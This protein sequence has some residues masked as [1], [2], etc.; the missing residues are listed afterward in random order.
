MPKIYGYTEILGDILV[1]GSFS[2]IGSASTINTTNLVVSDTIISLGHSQSG[3]PILDEG[4]MFGRGTGLTQAFIW[5]ESDDTFA[6]VSTNNDHTIIGDVNINSYSNLIVGG[7][8]TSTVKITNGA[9]NGYFL[10]SDAS[11]NATWAS[12]PVSPLTVGTTPVTSGTNGRLFFQELGIV[13]QDVSLFWDN[14]TKR[15]GIGGSAS[16]PQ[17]TL[18]VY[19]SASTFALRVGQATSNTDGSWTGISFFNSTTVTGGNTSAGQANIK[20]YR[21]SGG[22]GGEMEFNVGTSSV[23]RLVKE[24]YV[25]VGVITPSATLDIVS[26]TSSAVEINNTSTFLPSGSKYGINSTVGGSNFSLTNYGLYQSVS[27]ANTANYGAFSYVS[28][29]YGT[30]KSGFYA[31]VTDSNSTNTENSAFSGFISDGWKNTGLSLKIGGGSSV[32]GDTGVFVFLSSSLSSSQSTSYGSYIYN[33]STK[34]TK[35]GSYNRVVG[36]NLST[37]NYGMDSLISGANSVN[38]GISTR[39]TGTYGTTNLG[40]TSTVDSTG[41]STIYG[42]QSVVQTSNTTRAYGLYSIVNGATDFNVGVWGVVG[43]VPGTTSADVGGRFIVN[44]GATLSSSWGIYVENSSSGTGVKVGSGI[45]VSGYASGLYGQQIQMSA[46]SPANV[47]VHSQVIGTSGVIYG[48]SSNISALNSSNTIYGLYNTVQ[49]AQLSFGVYNSISGATFGSKYGVST[50]ITGTGSNF[51]EYI[52]MQSNGPVNYGIYIDSY[53]ATANYAVYTV[54]GT[55]VFNVGA[56]PN[57]DF[58]INGDTTNVFF[59][60]ASTDNIGIGTNVP[61]STAILEISSTTKGFLPPRMTAA[62]AELI[63]SPAEG[64]LVYSTDGLGVTITSKGWWGYTGATWTKLN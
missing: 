15:L 51:G 23:M 40:I 49:N 18:Q 60:K 30:T 43:N 64:L 5:D 42:I 36:D 7:L 1:T 14:T 44:S 33:N 20:A 31:Q 47:G 19:G 35:Y 57:S 56:D 38:T 11:G 61:N 25:G 63:S 32:N 12:I 52:G 55:S 13:Q 22:L 24:G 41:Q 34:G 58:Q 6:L 2:V 16:A 53:N 37:L 8:T 21:Y 29:T 48:Y 26:T 54:R 9:S 62:Q 45:I 39:V 50:I 4:I 3:S 27:G 10:Q 46:N 28:G 59:V 17:N